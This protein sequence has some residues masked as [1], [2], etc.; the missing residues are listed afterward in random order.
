[1][2]NFYNRRTD[3]RVGERHFRAR[4]SDADVQLVRALHE[5]HGLGYKALSKKFDQPRITIRDICA[6]R[7][8]TV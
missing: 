2:A 6:Y 8:R 1:M 3:R 4:L 5:E 7:R